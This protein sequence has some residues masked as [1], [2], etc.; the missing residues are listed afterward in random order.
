MNMKNCVRRNIRKYSDTK[1]NDKY[2]TLDISLNFGSLDK[3][4]ITSLEPKD[5]LGSSVKGLI[6]YLVIKAKAT[7][8]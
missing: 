1:D 7:P 4:R 6:A 8:K 2:I 5:N 3:M